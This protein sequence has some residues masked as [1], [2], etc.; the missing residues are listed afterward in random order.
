MEDIVQEVREHLDDKEMTRDRLLDISHRAIR[1]S[2]RA[3]AALHR[4]EEEKVSE[5]LVENEDDIGK[6]NDIIDSDPQFKSHGSVV[7]AHREYAE[8]AITR[9]II[10]EGDIPAP[11]DLDL[12]YKAYAQA[13]A[14]TIGE[15]R[16]YLLNLLRKDEIGRAQ[17]IHDKMEKIFDSLEQF[18]YPDS[19]LPGMKHRKDVARKT[20]EETRSDMTRI[21]REKRLEEKLD[22]TL[23]KLEG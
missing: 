13:M 1:N 18:D 11:G 8:A 16:R 14:E 19:I 3:V 7:A 6:L 23:R 20:L 22:E 17:D 10:N 15:L 4:G 21:V 2:S 9:S 5:L 12:L